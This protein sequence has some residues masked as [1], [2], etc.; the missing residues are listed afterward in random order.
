MPKIKA[1]TVDE[2][3]DNAP[4][5]AADKLNRLRAILREAAPDAKEIIKWNTPVYEGK[6]ILFSFSAFKAHIN[7]MPTG[8]SLDPFRDELKEYKM[9]K[10]TVQFPYNKP[11]PEAQIRKIAAYRVKDVNEND[12]LWMY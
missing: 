4:A 5:G 10:D 8:P 3:I 7:F 6:R 11:L 9:G 1:K 12:A 2:Y